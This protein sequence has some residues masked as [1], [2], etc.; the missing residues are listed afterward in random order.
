M[1]AY[2]NFLIVF[3][4]CVL[5]RCS[6]QV[7]CNPKCP[8]GY[9]CVHDVFP[10]DIIY[11]KK[12]GAQNADCATTATESI[13]PCSSGMYCHPNIDAPTFHSMYGKCR[14]KTGSP[15]VG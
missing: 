1:A 12:M 2:W 15:V 10:E 6:Y 8:V 14:P 4:F 3:T 11:C 7:D 5:I 9:C 13:C